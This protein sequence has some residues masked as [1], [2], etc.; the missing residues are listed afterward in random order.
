[1]SHSTSAATVTSTD[2][3]GS[4][5]PGGAAITGALALLIASAIGLPFAAVRLLHFLAERAGRTSDEIPAIEQ[6]QQLIHQPSV[7]AVILLLILAISLPVHT[8][9]IRVLGGGR[10][11]LRGAVGSSIMIQVFFLIPMPVL[12]A[13]ARAIRPVVVG[14][15][16]DGLRELDLFLML[17]VVLYGLSGIVMLPRVGPLSRARAGRCPI[18]SVLLRLTMLLFLGA[19]MITSWLGYPA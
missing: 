5:T 4:C 9:V 2:H 14:P 8:A 13:G 15:T 17:A 16:G 11:S 19:V 1:M 6:S 7:A 10:I 12:T 18:R 3:H